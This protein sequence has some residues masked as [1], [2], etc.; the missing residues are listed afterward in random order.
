MLRFQVCVN[1][2][3]MGFLG[4]EME[5]N[6]TRASEVREDFGLSVRTDGLTLLRWE[7]RVWQD[8]RIDRSWARDLVE[9]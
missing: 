2:E 3:P 7:G 1:M 8:G 9:W 5:V 6:E 4:E